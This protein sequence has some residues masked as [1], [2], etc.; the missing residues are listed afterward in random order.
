M[1]RVWKIPQGI[2]RTNRCQHR[3]KHELFREI[4]PCKISPARRVWM[5][6]AKK[7]IKMAQ[8]IIISWKDDQSIHQLQV[9]CSACAATYGGNHCL[10][11]T[12]SLRR[13]AIYAETDDF[14]D[15][16]AVGETCLPSG[17]DSPTAFKLNTI[18]LNKLRKSIE[19]I[20]ENDVKALHDATMWNQSTMHAD[21]RGLIEM[22]TYSD[23]DSKTDQATARGYRLR[24]SL[25]DN[26][27]SL[28]IPCRADWTTSS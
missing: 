15:I 24:L 1:V 25:S 20:D 12:E 4:Y 18:F 11:V 8:I 3:E 10:L 22:V 5:F 27:F 9:V 16:G 19:V 2:L 13:P 7:G 28:S 26:A 23:V 14:T 21:R 17:S 6:W